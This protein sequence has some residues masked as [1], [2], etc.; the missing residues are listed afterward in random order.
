MNMSR[1]TRMHKIINK[2]YGKAVQCVICN[3]KS[4]AKRCEWTNID[5]QYKM[6]KKYWRSLCTSCHRK[7][8]YEHLGYVCGNKGKKLSEESREKLSQ[9]LKGRKVWNKGLMGRQW[10]HNPIGLNTGVPW[11]KGIPMSEDMKKRLSI[12]NRGKS[13]WNK[14]VSGYKINRKRRSRHER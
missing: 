4:G 13:P 3:G 6:N 5:H 7:Y 1:Y 10:W 12:T 9:A 14:G 11:N 2:R 8:D